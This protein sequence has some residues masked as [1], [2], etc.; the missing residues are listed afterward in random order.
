MPSSSKR[1]QPRS[2]IGFC[3]FCCTKGLDC[4]DVA[5]KDSTTNSQS[6][7]ENVQEDFPKGKIL[8][9]LSYQRPKPTDPFRTPYVESFGSD[10]N[11]AGLRLHYIVLDWRPER[12]WIRSGKCVLNRS[13]VRS[14]IAHTIRI[15]CS[16]WSRSVVNT[17]WT[18]PVY[19]CTS[20]YIYP[21]M[22]PT[23]LICG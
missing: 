6:Y 21:P 1:F 4:S 17:S 12:R 9:L 3:Q 5:W 11:R 18:T 7:E 13:T 10:T 16:K 14:H 19:P 2:R 22:F 8:G 20:M 15:W 23:S